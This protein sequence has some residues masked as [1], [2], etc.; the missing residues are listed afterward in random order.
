MGVACALL[1]VRTPLDGERAFFIHDGVIG[2]QLKEALVRFAA[3]D[4]DQLLGILSEARIHR[5]IEDPN[6][7]FHRPPV[8]V[9][10]NNRAVVTQ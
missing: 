6:L 9:H 7:Q 1:R 3:G 2:G 8:L 10:S 4:V 5:F